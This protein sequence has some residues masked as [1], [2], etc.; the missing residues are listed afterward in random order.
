MAERKRLA[1][2]E[3]VLPQRTWC[4]ALD[5]FKGCDL[6]QNTNHEKAKWEKKK[7]QRTPCISARTRT[8]THGYLQRPFKA[9]DHLRLEACLDQMAKHLKAKLQAVTTVAYLQA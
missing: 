3:K 7:P 6:D 4:K 9:G 2:A 8:H 5:S 1:C